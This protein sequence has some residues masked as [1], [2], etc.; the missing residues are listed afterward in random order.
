RRE[1]QHV[2]DI[3]EPETSV[4]G[5]KFIRRIVVDSDQVP[6]CVAVF[7]AVEPPNRDAA[8]IGVLAIDAES[9]VLDPGFK[10]T[11]IA[12]RGLGLTRGRHDARANILQDTRP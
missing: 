4:V 2:T 6:D 10:G 5:W 1:C 12:V 9:P 11:S 8:R 7:D 3:V